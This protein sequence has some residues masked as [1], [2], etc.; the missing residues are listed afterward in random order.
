M[1]LDHLSEQQILAYQARTLSPSELLHL[2]DHLSS[3][4]AC[5]DR[6]WDNLNADRMV[7]SVRNQLHAVADP[8]VHRKVPTFVWTAAAAALLIAIG[9]GGGRMLRTP[10]VPEQVAQVLAQPTKAIEPLPSA[11]QEAFE[12]AKREGTVERATILN[13][14]IRKEG[15]LLSGGTAT[16]SFAVVAPMGT[17]VLTDRPWLKW[18]TVPGARLYTAAIF[19]ADFNKVAESPA[20]ASTE[21]QPSQPLP[22][23]KTYTW[24]VTAKVKDETIRFPRPPAPEAVFRVLDTSTADALEQT[25]MVRGDSHLLM[26]ILYA[27]VGLLDDAEAELKLADPR[28]AQKLLDSLSRI[29]R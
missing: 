26:G 28:E 14:L 27:N 25:R 8:S 24:Q 9:I 19:D 11:Y 21:W 10:A 7:T 17:V 4:A 20:L 12:R 6:M 5:R 22:R 1:S 13:E 29:R 16:P 3:C 15:T 23:G 2:D 18:Q